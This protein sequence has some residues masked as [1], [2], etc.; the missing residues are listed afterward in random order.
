[1]S[2][3]LPPLASIP[4]DLVAAVDYERRARSHLDD[5]A[6][7][8][9]AG[10]AADEITLQENRAAFDRL[11][12][13]GRVLADVKGGHTRLEFLG[14]TH[15]H[16]VLLAPVAYQRLFHADGELATAMAADAM[17]ACMVV[18]TLASVRMEDIPAAQQAARWFQLYFQAD[19]GQTLALLQRAESSG[20]SALVVTVDAPL[21]G[22]R[23]REQRAGFVLPKGIA[24][25]NLLPVSDAN[26]A[27]GNSLVFDVLMSKAPSWADIEWLLGQ[28]RLPVLLKGVLDADDAK[29]A[30]AHGIAGI[31]V[32]NH[33]GRVLDTLPAS[34]DA[35]PGV[36]AA[37]DRKIPVLLDGGIRR[38]TDIFKARALGAD[39]VL[40]GR[41]YIHAL[42]TA[43]ALGVAHLLRTLREE[44]EITMA[45]SG[46]K[47]LD[48]IGPDALFRG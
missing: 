15:A 31:I 2:K 8:Y 33:G 18:S 6:W 7:E 27:V 43:G 23:N 40:L 45:L 38:G 10:G 30:M 42:A 39:A 24:A 19:R 9:L 25:A 5:N 21:A 28:T 32:S 4:R 11:R 48:D 35:L 44:L 12:L 20:Y 37:I 14:Q 34:I 26:E 41:P 1:M 36:V 16:P 29:R 47:T 3:P 22:I 46:C 13:R 17:E